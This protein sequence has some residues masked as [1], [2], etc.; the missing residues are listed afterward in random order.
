MRALVVFE[1]MFGNTEMIAQSI[2][3]GLSTR[4]PVDVREVS[5]APSEIDAD[6]LLL[7]V[8][9]PTHAFGMTRP[10]TRQDAA[11]QSGGHLVSEGIGIREW[12][13][14]LRPNEPHH[15]TTATAF[16][17]RVKTRWAVPGSAAR[18]AVKR[19]S[20]LGFRVAAPAQSFYVTGTPGPLLEGERDRARQ[21]GETLAAQVETRLS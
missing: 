9:G 11:K 14:G 17:T 15:P 6:E 18:A 2:A 1:S 16:D 12:L 7:V 3:D 4:M 13:G 8:G 21:W 19:L 20:R 5:A 10:Q